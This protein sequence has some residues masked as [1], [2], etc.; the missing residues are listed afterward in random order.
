MISYILNFVNF[1][2][3]YES[4]MKRSMLNCMPCMLKSCSHANVLCVVTCS[5]ANVP[6]VLTYSRANVPCVVK[7]SRANVP[8]VST[9]SR[10]N[11]LCML[12]RSRANVP[13]V[14]TCLTC[15]YVLRAYVLTSQR[16]LKL[17]RSCANM[18]WVPCLTQLAWPYDHL[19]TRFASLVSSSDSIFFSF[20]VIAVEVL[21]TVGKV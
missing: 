6:W 8:C 17:T 18:P 21:H 15:Q 5:R 3:C 20:T 7:C 10:A 14:L 12:S 16:G 19:P 1:S 11:V 9:Y 4:I 13:W 2:W